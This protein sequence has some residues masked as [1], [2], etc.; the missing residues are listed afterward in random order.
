M[1]F[2]LLTSLDDL[3]NS[4]PELAAE[5][6][7]IIQWFHSR[8]RNPGGLD[9]PLYQTHFGVPVPSTLKPL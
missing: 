1:R 8:W 3:T 7:T 5:Q 9:G 2:M 6:L 4:F